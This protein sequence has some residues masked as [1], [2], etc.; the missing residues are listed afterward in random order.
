MSS[1]PGPP[2]TAD[3]LEKNPELIKSIDE[4]VFYDQN[5]KKWLFELT[6]GDTTNEY[7]YN[8]DSQQWTLKILPNKRSRDEAAIDEEE[9]Q[10]K[11]ELKRLKKERS[12]R[13][14]AEIAKLKSERLENLKKNTDSTA[15]YVTNL[16]EDVTE[17]ELATTF[18]KYGLLSE[19]YNTGKAR[20]KLQYEDEKFKR[21][22]LI[23]YLNKE[24]VPLSIEMLD[25]SLLR[26]TDK[27]RIRVEAAQFNSEKL[28]EK[29]PLSEE[30]KK[31]IKQTNDK[32]K[33]KVT[34]WDEDLDEASKLE[35]F[36]EAKRKILDK[37]VV[38]DQMFR[39]DEYNKDPMLEMDI[40]EDIQEECNKLGIGNDITKISFE[41]NGRVKIKFGKIELSRICIEKFNGRYFD[42]IKLEV[43]VE[44]SK[45]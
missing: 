26:Q 12:M 30:E 23:I 40:K 41:E 36:N 39:E 25:D 7:E 19:D 9:E 38:I 24:S 13:I 37:I 29:K 18:G 5:S 1:F 17:E 3:A 35:R 2:P 31:R 14:K 28:K 27:E 34:N 21:E 42:G 45:S 16:P 43:H 44:G 10:N 11:L 6:E 20:I 32:L 33:A 8:F 4:R 22:A 15:V